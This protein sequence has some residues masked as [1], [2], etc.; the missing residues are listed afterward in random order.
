MKKNK[1]VVIGLCI[2]T[3]SI[4]LIMILLNFY[5]SN[6][7]KDRVRFEIVYEL[8]DK[9]YGVIYN[10]KNKSVFDKYNLEKNI[11][12]DLLG[13]YIGEEAI[14]VDYDGNFETFKIYK[15]ANAPI[16]KYAWTPR[17]I[18]EATNGEYYHATIGSHYNSEFY[19]VDE[20]KSVYGIF[21]SEDIVSISN[22]KDE[23]IVDRDF[24]NQFYTGLF[25]DDF[26]DNDFLQENV[27]Q[28][29]GIDESEIDKLYTKYAD[30]MNYLFVELSNGIVLS[31]KFTSHNY[32]EVF[33]GLYFKVDDSWLALVSKLK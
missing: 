13:E 28:N 8:N 20:V 23:K 27:F 30:D 10:S 33:H 18:L 17:L 32:V 15:Y 14:R 19:S 1:N 2:V 7:I 31:V 21:S 9:I 29:T 16:T 12:S 26:G 11:T 5:K 25:T 22:E 3:V 4:V 24:I 6:I